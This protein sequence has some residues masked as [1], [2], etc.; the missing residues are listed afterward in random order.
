MAEK[1]CQNDLFEL[2]LSP[3]RN[4]LLF[5]CVPPS[6]AS[7]ARTRNFSDAENDHIGMQK[8]DQKIFVSLVSFFSTKYDRNIVA[9]RVVPVG[10]L[11]NESEIDSLMSHQVS[12]I[13][14][15]C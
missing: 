14:A 3:A 2:V 12:I 13:L 9:L 11:I 1:I 4:F 8:R 6:L 5:R 15:N 10:Q 7:N